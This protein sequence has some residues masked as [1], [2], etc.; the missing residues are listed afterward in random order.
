MNDSSL[1]IVSL[2]FK[3]ME[4]IQVYLITDSID[5]FCSLA[6]IVIFYTSPIISTME[7][8]VK[9]IKQQQRANVNFIILSCHRYL[10]NWI[11]GPLKII[12]SHGPSL[13]YANWIC[14]EVAQVEWGY[15][16][17]G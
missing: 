17:W 14:T 5:I 1:F 16:E 8:V 3:P 12:Y 15:F 4:H 7:K 11:K 6:S 10:L 9:Q 13:T 2:E